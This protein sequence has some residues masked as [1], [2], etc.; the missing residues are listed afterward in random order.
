M[1]AAGPSLLD[2]MSP[3]KASFSVCPRGDFYPPDEWPVYQSESWNRMYPGSEDT[4]RLL[5]IERTE[6]IVTSSSYADSFELDDIVDVT[7]DQFV[8]E[9]EAHVTPTRPMATQ[10]SVSPAPPAMPKSKRARAPV[11]LTNYIVD[12][13][14]RSRRTD[15]DVPAFSLS[16]CS[17]SNDD[18][19]DGTETQ[20]AS[21]YCRKRTPNPRVPRV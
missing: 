21:Q 15:L 10:T 16:D 17:D 9:L 1:S 3:P 8:S 5:E 2:V 18:S 11:P 19:D 12:E 6:S 4:Q 14:H 20:Y 13:Y 7:P